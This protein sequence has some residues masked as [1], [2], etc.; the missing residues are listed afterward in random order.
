MNVKRSLIIV[1]ALVLTITVIQGYRMVESL[2]LMHQGEPHFSGQCEAVYGV[3]GAEDITIDQAHKYAYI[4]ADDRRA[5]RANQAVS[6]GIYGLDLS[7]PGASPVLL[8]AAFSEDFHPHGISLYKNQAGER[9]LF[10]INHLSRGPDQVEIFDIKD[11]DDLV[12][13]SSITY[14]A[15]IAPND[16]VAVGPSQFYVTNDHAYPPGHMMQMVENYLGLALS[17]VSYFDGAKGSLVASGFR[18]ANGIAISPDLKTLYVAEVTGRKVT[19]FDRDLSSAALSK[20]GEIPINSGADNLEW[21][22]TGNLWLGAHPRLLDF[23]AHSQDSGNISPS[24][25]IKINGSVPLHCCHL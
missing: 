18:Y 17:S 20:R 9:S 15:L 10:V 6:G 19:I 7:S 24:Q 22:E 25:V 16:L 11:V 21:D 4:S 13:R 8:T 3:V 23:A 14:P 12:H 1:S 2:G 5:T